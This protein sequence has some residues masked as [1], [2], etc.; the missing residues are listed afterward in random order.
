MQNT[1]ID[2]MTKHLSSSILS[3]SFSHHIQHAMDQKHVPQATKEFTHTH[4][5]LKDKNPASLSNTQ[6]FLLSS[7]SASKFP[8]PRSDTELCNSY[9]LPIDA[10]LDNGVENYVT[11]LMPLLLSKKQLGRSWMRVQRHW[12]LL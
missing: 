12:R 9:S 8:T 10:K 5:Y 6:S 2:S 7:P 1:Q 11:M 3:K 4:P